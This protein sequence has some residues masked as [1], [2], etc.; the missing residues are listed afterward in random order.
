MHKALTTGTRVRWSL[1]STLVGGLMVSMLVGA[2]GGLLGDGGSSKNGS[3]GEAGTAA[4]QAGDGGGGQSAGRGGQGDGGARAGVAGVA[5]APELPMPNLCDEISPR[6]PGCPCTESSQCDG[7]CLAVASP[8]PCEVATEGICR[9]WPFGGCVCELGDEPPSTLCIERELCPETRPQDQETCNV[10]PMACD[11]DDGEHE[12]C[13]CMTRF[14]ESSW[15]CNAEDAQC[16]FSQPTPESSCSGSLSCF[17]A[18]GSGMA[19]RCT[20]S[21][22]EWGCEAIEG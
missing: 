20:C 7:Y 8:D 11:Y 18:T 10:D 15:I 16:P 5:G 3:G 22:S 9:N 12:R 13:W 17:Y 6:P 14:G 19:Y 1:H 4:P 2:C 21:G